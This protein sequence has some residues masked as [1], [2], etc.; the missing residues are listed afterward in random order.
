MINIMYK[1][2][3]SD[4]T[5]SSHRGVKGNWCH[6]SRWSICKWVYIWIGKRVISGG[7]LQSWLM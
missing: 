4:C 2:L 5:S 1:I 7:M 6:W 3:L